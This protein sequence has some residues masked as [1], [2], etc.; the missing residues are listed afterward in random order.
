MST[1]FFY[2][3]EAQVAIVKAQ[4]ELFDYHKQHPNYRPGKGR[5]H[6]H[7]NPRS[8]YIEIQL[9]VE[10]YE[11][12][13]PQRAIARM[14]TELTVHTQPTLEHLVLTLDMMV[15]SLNG[16]HPVLSYRDVGDRMMLLGCNQVSVNND[17]T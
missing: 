10:Q 15:D 13:E 14:Q 11:K 1:D 4:K 9:R 5:P 2:Q 17:P 6:L 16:H 7:I 3:D 12:E 8:S